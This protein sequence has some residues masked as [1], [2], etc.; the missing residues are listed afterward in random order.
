MNT[1]PCLELTVQNLRA[2]I[3]TEEMRLAKGG[4]GRTKAFDRGVAKQTGSITEFFTKV[5]YPM[6][7]NLVS[8]PVQIWRTLLFTAAT[9]LPL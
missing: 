1:K 3:A 5:Y 4:P 9:L 2:N 6:M 7:D 8:V